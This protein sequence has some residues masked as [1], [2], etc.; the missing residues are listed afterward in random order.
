M[1][2]W[3]P[4]GAI[5][6]IKAPAVCNVFS[7]VWFGSES[8]RGSVVSFLINVDSEVSAS[9]NKSPRIYRCV[10]LK[11]PDQYV[12]IILKKSL[13]ICI[14]G[15]LLV[16]EES[17][18]QHAASFRKPLPHCT[19]L[20]SHCCTSESRVALQKEEIDPRQK[21]RRQKVKMSRIQYFA[22]RCRLNS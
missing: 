21:T 10:W 6:W 15:I 8:S 18:H 5:C 2:L 3:G 9:H 20:N 1:P 4:T 14:S 17:Q 22:F 11:R 16:G 7:F 19:F 13:N 12:C